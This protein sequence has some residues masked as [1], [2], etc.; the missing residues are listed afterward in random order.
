[1]WTWN[2]RYTIKCSKTDIIKF[3]NK[4]INKYENIIN[5]N[6]KYNQALC[7][8]TTELDQLVEHKFIEKNSEN[9]PICHMILIGKCVTYACDCK[10][11][12]HECCMLQLMIRG[13]NKCPLC[14]LQMSLAKM[15]TDIPNPVLPDKIEIDRK[16]ILL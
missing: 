10:L 2:R 15:K 12:I 16:L 4:L 1:M 5:N 6:F 3:K 13:F 11:T 9:C 7:K 8:Y 14:Q